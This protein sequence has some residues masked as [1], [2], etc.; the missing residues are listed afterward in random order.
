MQSTKQLEHQIGAVP[1]FSIL[2]GD[3]VKSSKGCCVLEAA[4]DALRLPGSLH[5][6]FPSTALGAPGSLAS[7]VIG[8]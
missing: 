5:L 6:G 2:G 8:T 1:G 7:D 3:E 4:G